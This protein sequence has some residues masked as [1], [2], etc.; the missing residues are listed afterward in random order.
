MK[1]TQLINN[2]GNPAANQFVIANNGAV[3]FQSYSTM[4]AKVEDGKLTL[5]SYWDYSKTTS[6]HLYIFLNMYGFGHL[7]SAVN[8]RR[9]I[10]NGTVSFVNVIDY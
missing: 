5:S 7:D 1:V 2:N 3:Y 6:K 4:I 9:A 10:K 8:V